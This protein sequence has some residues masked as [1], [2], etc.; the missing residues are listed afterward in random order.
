VL[1]T[2]TVAYVAYHYL[3][4]ATTIAPRLSAS[5]SADDNQARAVYLQ[6]LIGVL[7][8]GVL[9]AGVTFL[10]G[11]DLA[12]CGLAMGD[13][14]AAAAVAVAGAAAFLPVAYLSARRPQSWAHYPQVRATIWTRRTDAVNAATWVFYLAG[15]ELF[16]RGFL[17]FAMARWLGDAP[18]IAVTTLAYVFAHLP[19]NGAECAGTIPAGAL[20]AA[21]ALYTGAIWAPLLVHIV[22][23]VGTD[24]FVTRANPAIVRRPGASW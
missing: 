17:L 14:P 6:R 11:R 2:V 12:A 21:G 7:L 4:H 19:K 10:L 20:F 3:G 8:L 5:R 23:A 1:A 13:L 16:F 15:Y 22:V 24:V 18:A 9:P